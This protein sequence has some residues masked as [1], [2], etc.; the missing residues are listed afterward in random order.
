[1]KIHKHPGFFVDI[2]GIDGSGASTQVNLVSTRLKEAGVFPYVT[3]EPTDGDVGKLIH[4]VLRK[5]PRRLSPISLELLFASDRGLHL[6]EVIIPRL[7]KGEMVITDRYAWASVAYGC[8]YLTKEWLFDLNKDFIFPDLTI[9]IDVSPDVC[10]ER[11][12]KE[13]KGYLLFNDPEL[14]NRVWDVYQWLASKYWWAPIAQING[15]RPKEQITEDILSHIK[16]HPKF[17][18]Y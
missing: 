5:H 15:E 2:E 4:H 7:E 1:M 9:F 17:K 8:I 3:K 11:L 18:L 13:K 10:M 12:K 6:D 14:L 16:K